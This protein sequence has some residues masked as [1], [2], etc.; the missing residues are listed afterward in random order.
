[1]NYYRRFKMHFLNHRTK[2]FI[3]IG[4]VALIILSIYGMMSLESYY[5][6]ITLAQMPISILLVMVNALIFVYLYVVVL[7]NGFTTLD[8]KGVK[9]REVDVHFKDVVGIDEAKE[10]AWEVV[11]LIKDHSRL[12]KIGGKILR[13]ILMIGPPGCGKTYLAKAIATEAGLPFLSMAAS[14][15]NE[16]F[17]G[18]GASRVR[19]LFSK[20]RSLSYGFGGAIIFIDELDAMGRTRTFNQFGGAETNTTQNQL[21]VEMDGLES[22]Q[23]NIVVIGATNA[24]EDVLD[25]ALLRPGR[26]DRKVY[27]MKPGLEGREAIFRLYLN[28]IKHEASVD[29]ARLARKAVGKSPAE[30]EN[31]IKEAALIATRNHKEMVTNKEFSEA[32]ERIEL[33]TK[34]KVRMTDREK[35]MTAYHETGHLITTYLLHPRN[36]VFKA[37]IIPR[38]T[39]LGVV[40]PQPR[41][42][43][44]ADDKE[45]ILADIKCFL[46]GY[47]GEKIKFN[48]TS[49]GV[50]ADFQAA[51]HLA[52]Q[53]V[54]RYGMGSNGLV[55]DF[56]VIPE[57]Q[58]SED[59]KNRLN[60]ETNRIIQQ[61]LK[62]VEDLLARE[63]ELFERF[64]HE[65]LTRE[66]LD[67]DEIEAIFAEFGKA[68][69][70]VISPT[71][72]N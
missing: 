27:I 39:T 65:L 44:F 35:Q 13:G 38:K 14:E 47:A 7:R 62:E 63:K 70:R 40:H 50:A 48:Q 25:P 55:G 1:M 18:V 28:K 4:V 26:F 31:I 19:K 23:E 16:V 71:G 3:S 20:A 51:M 61:C 36:D 43:W 46:A 56:T 37:S 8:K 69:P 68:N 9:A 45:K 41:E 5:R 12:K 29:V 33:G 2:I 11:Q 10:E 6:N 57:H 64:A 60:E 58:L 22:H 21:L 17:V 54:W 59:I 52:H 42:E 32:I 72:S 66:E 67:Y 34:H 49:N 53:M 30:I 15:F 24:P